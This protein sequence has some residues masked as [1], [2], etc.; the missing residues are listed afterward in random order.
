MA[1]KNKKPFTLAKVNNFLLKLSKA[2]KENRVE[3][4]YDPPE[5]GGVNTKLWIIKVESNNVTLQS[6]SFTTY[7]WELTT[8]N[9]DEFLSCLTFYFYTDI[10]TAVDRLK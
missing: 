3:V 4:Y 6:N 8:E 9:I 1:R 5:Q 10:Y 7:K 2:M